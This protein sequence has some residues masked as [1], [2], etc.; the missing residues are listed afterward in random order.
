MKRIE[1]IKLLEKNGWFK[2]ATVVDTI[3]IQMELNEN[4]SQGTKR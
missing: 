3:F 2:N 1:L 4:Q